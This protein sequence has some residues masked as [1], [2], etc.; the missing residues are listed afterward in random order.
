MVQ[1]IGEVL[2]FE[3]GQHQEVP[4]RHV[5]LKMTL[6]KLGFSGTYV[7]VTHLV[8]G[9]KRLNKT[10]P[11]QNCNPSMLHCAESDSNLK[12]NAKQTN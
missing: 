6:E 9:D 2:D 1:A 12:S 11:N 7:N 4:G 3:R 10:K 8:Q 5:A